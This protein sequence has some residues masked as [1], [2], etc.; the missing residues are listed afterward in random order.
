MAQDIENNHEQ[1]EKIKDFVQRNKKMIIGLVV[2]LFII[3][4]GNDFY[5]SNKSK[6]LERL[7]SCFKNC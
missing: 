3:L 6:I 2:A 4:I 1:L 7:L 5:K